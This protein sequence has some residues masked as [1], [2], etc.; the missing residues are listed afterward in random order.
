[1]SLGCKNLVDLIDAN[2]GTTS[3]SYPT[4]QKIM[5]INLA[6]DKIWSLIFQASGIWHFDD[7][8]HTDY[9]IITTNLVSGQRDYSFTSDESGNLI[10]EIF[11]VMVADPNGVFYDLQQVNQNQANAESMSMVDG[12]NIQGQPSKY[13]KTANGIFLDAIP[14]YSYDNGLKLFI[15]REAS[16]FVAL[17]TFYNTKKPGFAG[18]FHE[19]LALRPSYMYAYRKGLQNVKALQTEMLLMEDKIEEYYSKRNKDEKTWTIP[20]YRSSR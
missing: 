19:Y 3:T 7:S 11:R 10:L 6:L 2:C 5:D 14:N 18:I 20:K 12:Q 17:D 8:N 13:N 1:M 4:A 9:P 15:D 16:Y